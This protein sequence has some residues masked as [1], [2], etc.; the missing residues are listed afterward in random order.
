MRLIAFVCAAIATLR[1]GVL[2]TRAQLLLTVE[3]MG[4]FG[5]F[6]YALRS[7]W[8]GGSLYAPTVATPDQVLDGRWM[9]LLDLAP[10]HLHLLIAPFAVAP[11]PVA[12]W[13]WLAINVA[14]LVYAIIL[15]VRELDLRLS[16]EA[17]VLTLTG[18]L[19]VRPWNGA[20]LGQYA[21][22]LAVPAT[23]AWKAAR[24]N[25]WIVAFAWLGIIL[26]FKPFVILFALHAA[27]HRRWT[28]IAVL[29]G[30]AALCAVP[31][32]LVFG[33]RSYWEW[34]SA[35]STSNSWMWLYENMSAGGIL[36][37]TLGSN[38]VFAPF[39][40]ASLHVIAWLALLA[41]VIVAATL[42][43]T[44]SVNLDEAWVL[45]WMAG[46]LASPLGWSYYVWWAMGPIVAVAHR[47][48]WVARTAVGPF[49]L[50]LALVLPLEVTLVGQPSPWAT[51]T[52]GSLSGWC[53]VALWLLVALPCRSV[54]A[55]Q[56]A[57]PPQRVHDA[58]HDDHHQHAKGKR[59]HE[60][61]FT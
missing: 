58:Q 30:T 56:P 29:L 37:R 55:V 18:L 53:G 19:F 13:L 10:P 52:F 39:P 21:F 9:P 31:G 45:L 8:A 15:V 28:A 46:L 61:S 11:P 5:R 59:T 54:S 26:S 23:L 33:L 38:P 2:V 35:L 27:L 16:P 1:I 60:P 17:W 20:W 24:R 14:S 42:W 51:L 12:F 47:R 3:S 40:N 49:L 36:A 7:W 57:A 41:A 48:R 32:V 34:T 6:Y 44:L 50:G 43:R 4:D 25:D 22:L